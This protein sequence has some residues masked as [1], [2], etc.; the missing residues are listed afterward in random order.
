MYICNYFDMLYVMF[1]RQLY[2]AV[3]KVIE[4]NKI[5]WEVMGTPVTL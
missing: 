1:K 5:Y 3:E 2:L 4:I